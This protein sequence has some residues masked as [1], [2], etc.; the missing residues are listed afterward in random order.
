M[1]S[2]VVEYKT[3]NKILM[4]YAKKTGAEFKSIEELTG[5]GKELLKLNIDAV[6]QRYNEKTNYDFAEKFEFKEIQ[7]NEFEIL[8]ALHCF[9]YQCSEGNIPNK[10]LYKQMVELENGI[11]FEII[12]KMPEYQKA[13]WG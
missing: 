9:T 10:K 5:F 4:Y 2:F 11:A 1:S 6:N 3:I 13:E 12:D 8:K 7:C